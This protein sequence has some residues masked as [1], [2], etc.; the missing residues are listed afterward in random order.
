M[1]LMK[2]VI[3]IN[4]LLVELKTVNICCK[5][6]GIPST[7]LGYADDVATCCLS[8]WKLDRAMNIVYNHGCTWR[9]QLNAKKSG[10]LVYG[11]SRRDHDNNSIERVFRL[12]PRQVKERTVYDHVGIRN[13]IFYEDTTGIEERI[14]KGCRVFNALTGIGIRKGGV[15]MAICSVVFWTVVVPTALYGCELWV[16]CDASLTSVEEFKNY[17]GKRIQRLH[18]K[19]LN[20]C[21]FYTLGWMRLERYI[22]IKKLMFIRTILIM[23]DDELPKQIFCERSKFFFN[24]NEIPDPDFGCSTVLDL[25]NVS[26][27][28][29]LLEEVKN[30]VERNLWYTKSAWKD[31]VWKK[32]WTLEDTYWRIESAMHRS[33]NLMYNVCPSS[34]YL[35]WWSISDRY[36]HYMKKCEIMCKL[37]CH[38]SALRSDDF[39]LKSQL[40]TLRM[41]DLCGVFEIQD[42]RHF[43]MQ[44]SY[45]QNERDAMLAEVRQI[46]LAANLN[47]TDGNTDLLYVLLGKSITGLDE[48][49]AE[50]LYFTVLD[51]IADMYR[52]NVKYKSGIG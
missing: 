11:E 48:N 43:V 23:K 47:F 38:S 27:L 8:K 16:M 39:K 25:L 5:I 1:S 2:Y 14:S 15:T 26:Y 21:S 24:N 49:L 7:P 10:V 35:N 33:M 17:I 4:S 44:C 19:N 29:G 12:G 36:P 41:C 22:Q 3:F 50:R 40:G 18:P 32:G 42:A 34:R 13:S 6:F 46:E 31:N 28:F 37:I 45:F 9:Y 20:T 30:M 52:K 51:G